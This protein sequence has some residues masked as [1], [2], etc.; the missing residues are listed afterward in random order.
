MRNLFIYIDKIIIIINDNYLYLYLVN[1]INMMASSR[2]V[3]V[4]RIIQKRKV[5]RLLP[6]ILVGSKKE[7]FSLLSTSGI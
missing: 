1:F 3:R 6:A 5:L 2:R 7:Y 4:S